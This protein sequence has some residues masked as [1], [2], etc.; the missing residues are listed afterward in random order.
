MG[1]TEQLRGLLVRQLKH[2]AARIIAGAGVQQLKRGAK[3]TIAW[4]AG[5]AAAAS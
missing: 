1:Q 2:G 4:A 3:R 5:T